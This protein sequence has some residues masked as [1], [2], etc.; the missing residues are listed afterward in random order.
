MLIVGLGSHDMIIGRNF[1]NYFR[2]LID[3]HYHRLHWPMEFPPTKTYARTV[4]VYTRDEI[5]PRR[6]QLHYQRDAFRRDQAIARDDKRRRD[7]VHIKVLT[8]KLA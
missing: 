7:G 5:R 2:V 8:R 4:A 6:I 3:V 1:F